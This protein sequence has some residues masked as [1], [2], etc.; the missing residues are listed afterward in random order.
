MELLYLIVFLRMRGI[1][2]KDLVHLF[3]TSSQYKVCTC[4]F[5]IVSFRE[6]LCKRCCAMYSCYHSMRAE[7]S[8][9]VSDKLLDIS[10]ISLLIFDECHHAKDN[11]PYN[12]IMRIY[13]NKKLK[14][15]K[16]VLPQVIIV[17]T[18]RCR[19]IKLLNCRKH[20]RPSENKAS[21]PL[22]PTCFLYELFKSH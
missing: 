21:R 19:K 20:L 7:N 16:E 10:S 5:S 6:V 12:Q 2:G 1:V 3:V 8:F 17:Y 4:Y 14:K 13:L 15:K 9:I 22:L 11:E 18:Q